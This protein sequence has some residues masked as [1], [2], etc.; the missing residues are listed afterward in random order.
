MDG[1][2]LRPDIFIFYN[3]CLF[4]G[5]YTFR[6]HVLNGSKCIFTILNVLVT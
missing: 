5:A 4:Q 1:Q 6:T 2:V 3:S